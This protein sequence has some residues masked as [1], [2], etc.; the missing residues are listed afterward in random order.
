MGPNHPRPKVG[1]DLPPALRHGA[2]SGA[3]SRELQEKFDT[4]GPETLPYLSANVRTLEV[5]GINP[6]ACC[7]AVTES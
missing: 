5:A 2:A 3:A 4:A 1:A 6:V 7:R